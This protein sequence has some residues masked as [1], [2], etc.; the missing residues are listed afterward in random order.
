MG[1][2]VYGLIAFELLMAV[3]HL[4]FNSL[5]IHGVRTNNP[6]MIRAW[7]I[8]Q[9][10]GLII[11]LILVVGWIIVSPIVLI[12]LI[13]MALTCYFMAVVKSYQV[14]MEKAVTEI[15]VVENLEIGDT[16]TGVVNKMA[17]EK[18]PPSYTECTERKE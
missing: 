10:V 17:E 8:Y 12:Y 18:Q 15:R 14:E 11:V 7:M 1:E 6:R 13:P 9:T 3:M 4:A 2:L 5:L 16:H